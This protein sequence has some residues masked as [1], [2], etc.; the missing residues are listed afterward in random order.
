MRCSSI[1]SRLIE[2]V[3]SVTSDTLTP[4]HSREAQTL[5]NLILGD[6]IITAFRLANDEF[7]DL[8]ILG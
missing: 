4:E 7:A 1:V 5:G 8:Q 6:L 2:D 3:V